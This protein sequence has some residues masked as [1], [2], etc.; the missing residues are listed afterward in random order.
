MQLKKRTIYSIYQ[1]YCTCCTVC[2]RPYCTCCTVCCRPYCTCCTVC[3]RPYCTCCTVCCRPYCTCCTVC[4]RPYCTCCTVCCRPYC[5]CCTVCCRPYC[6]CCTVCC[7]I[8]Q[9][10][11]IYTHTNTCTRYLNC[12]RLHA[13][14]DGFAGVSEEH[15][16]RLQGSLLLRVPHSN[17][18]IG[19]EGWRAGGG[20]EGRSYV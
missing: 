15:A 16:R 2:C 3:C 8:K 20:K 4:C 19:R 11:T 1:P 14:N 18:H 6:T 7:S 10:S 13:P 5:T 9:C 17:L 12:S